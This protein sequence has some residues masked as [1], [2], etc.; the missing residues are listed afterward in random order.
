MVNRRKPLKRS[1]E[2]KRTPMRARRRPSGIRV[3]PDGREICD[4]AAWRIRTHEIYLRDGGRCFKCARVFPE[5]M[6]ECDH[7]LKRGMGG[8]TRDDR[9]ANLRTACTWCHA[10]RHA[11]ENKPKKSLDIRHST[12]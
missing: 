5:S 6:T 12:T 7:I 3:M 1:G 9:P 4:G 10:A 11:E 8:G 2:L